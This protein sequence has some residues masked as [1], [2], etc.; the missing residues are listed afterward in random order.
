MNLSEAGMKKHGWQD[1]VNVTTEL[2][3]EDFVIIKYG[4]MPLASKIGWHC[5]RLNFIPFSFV[6]KAKSSEYIKRKYQ[7]YLPIINEAYERFVNN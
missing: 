3:A 2:E 5:L 6:S 4:L 1:Q 7:R